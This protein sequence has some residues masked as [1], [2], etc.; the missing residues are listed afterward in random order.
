MDTL[1]KRNKMLSL[2]SQQWIVKTKICL[3]IINI[4]KGMVTLPTFYVNGALSSILYLM[5]RG[6]QCLD[7]CGKI[8]DEC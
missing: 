8:Q 5:L 7:Y 1:W 6:K 2:Q 3:P 4:D